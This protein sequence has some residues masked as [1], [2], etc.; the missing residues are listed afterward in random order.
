M[1]TRRKTSPTTPAKKAQYIAKAKNLAGR[2]V[3]GLGQELKAFCPNFRLVGLALH[4]GAGVGAGYKTEVAVDVEPLVGGLKK[5]M[6]AVWKKFNFKTP[7][8]L[9]KLTD[10]IKALKAKISS[11]NHKA[12]D[13]YEDDTEAT[14]SGDTG[15][16]AGAKPP[17][18][19][20]GAGRPSGRPGAKPPG[21][22]PGGKPAGGRKK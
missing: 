12:A 20:P 6:Q 1:S 7:A 18:G 11:T 4:V 13:D 21:G 5:G 17:G 16:K 22:R 9:G 8:W 2:I 3:A 15:A 14:E 10:S 19:R